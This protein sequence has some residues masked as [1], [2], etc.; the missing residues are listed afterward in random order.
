MRVVLWSSHC[1]RI[2]YAGVRVCGFYHEIHA[3]QPVASVSRTLLFQVRALS[4][5][6]RRVVD[7]NAP[8]EQRKSGVR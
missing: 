5:R 8:P 4:E 1:V 6:V 3:V 7:R 2:I